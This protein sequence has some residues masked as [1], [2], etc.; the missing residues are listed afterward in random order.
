MNRP[1]PVKAAFQAAPILERQMFL[2]TERPDIPPSYGLA[3]V[4]GVWLGYDRQLPLVELVDESGRPVGALLGYVF[5]EFTEE[6][7]GA[8]KIQ[9]PLRV[10]DFADLE[11]QVLP[12]FG[13]TY[14]LLTSGALAGRVYMDHGGSFPVVYSSPDRRAASSAA[15]LLSEAEYT[16]RFRRDLHA[17]LVEREGFG[18]WIAGTLTAHRDVRRVL[19]NHYLDLSSWTTHRYWPRAGDFGTWR[20]FDTS[21]DAAARAIERFSAA[22]SR[23]FRVAVTLTAGSD[24]RLL[25]AG[26]RSGLSDYEFFTL[27]APGA[28][29]DVGVSRALASRFG[30][31][32]RAIALKQATETETAV[33]DRMVGD[34]VIEAPRLTHVTL[35]ELTHHDAMFTGICGEVGRCRLYRQDYGHINEMRIDARFLM[36]R[37]TLPRVPEL[38]ADIAAWLAELSGQPNSV[39]LDL[40]YHEL[41]AGSWAMSQRPITNSIKLNFIPFAQRAVL[42]AF[43]GVEPARK[44]N[45]ELFRATISNLWPELSTVPINKYGDLRDLVVLWKK[46]ITPNRLRRYLRDR[47]AG[48]KRAPA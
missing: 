31:T 6:F 8:G 23:T 36:D 45:H 42:E 39:I 40:A 4:G 29:R 35:R 17:V 27:D 46:L 38:Q 30:F 10:N 32:H 21:V 20:D 14:L 19:P 24:S 18:G 3:E 9:L 12:R 41:K 1:V 44:G 34:C 7:L 48:A 5:S 43:I 26:C 37:L 16:E 28:E 25:L 47:L 13:G 15:L 2:A 22:A 33:W 11:A